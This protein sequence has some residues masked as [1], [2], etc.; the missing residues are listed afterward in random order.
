VGTG[1]ISKLWML[2]TAETES[3]SITL[4]SKQAE[5]DPSLRYRSL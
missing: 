5:V 3:F 4:I 1:Q 2:R